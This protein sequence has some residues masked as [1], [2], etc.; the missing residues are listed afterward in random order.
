MSHRIEITA[1]FD[2][3][4]VVRFMSGR[5]TMSGRVEAIVVTDYGNGPFLQYHVHPYGSPRM[6]Y[7]LAETMRLLSRRAPTPRS[8][9]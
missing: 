2:I 6:Y 7:P 8:E 9:P 3:G 5:R 4:D 1:E